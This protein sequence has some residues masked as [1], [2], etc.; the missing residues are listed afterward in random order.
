MMSAQ[1]LL[2]KQTAEAFSGRLDMPLR[3]SLNGISQEEG[4]W[5]PDEATPTIEQVARHIAWAKFRYCEEGFHCPM[6]LTDD[7]V[8]ADGDSDQLP[9]EF[10]CGAAWGQ[11][12]V[13]KNSAIRSS[14][15][16]ID[17]PRSSTSPSV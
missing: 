9:W 15:L 8:N 4:S 3:A 1:Q 14:P 7:S 11:V 2:L 13:F 17:T 10:P 16:S 12:S 5:A 6:V